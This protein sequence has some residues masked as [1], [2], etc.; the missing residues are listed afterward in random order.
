MWERAGD[1]ATALERALGSLA[2]ALGGASLGWLAVGVALHLGNQVA[3][4]RGWYAIV[5]TATSGRGLTP[6]A[7]AA[8]RNQPS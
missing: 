3:R 2:E 7:R 8:T 5:R 1:L 4:G 6:S